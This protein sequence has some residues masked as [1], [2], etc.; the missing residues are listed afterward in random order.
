MVDRLAGFDCEST[1]EKGCGEGDLGRTNDAFLGI[2]HVPR[3]PGLE[4]GWEINKQ[5]EAMALL[6]EG[7][8]K[9]RVGHFG[10]YSGLKF[11]RDV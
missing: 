6:I 2:E 4:G 10:V 3:E 7:R 5:I 11:E 1:M 9:N 8:M